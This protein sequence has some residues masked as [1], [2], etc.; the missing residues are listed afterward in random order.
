MTKA[1]VKKS[2]EKRLL[3][4]VYSNIKTFKP[5]KFKIGDYV[6]ISYNP[7]LFE[8]G[9][10]PN[11]STEIFQVRKVQLTNPVSY[12]LSDYQHNNVNGGFYEPELQLCN[13][14]KYVT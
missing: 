8:K 6:R 14:P 2:D 10:T 5:G 1:K 3:S 11:W 7:T 4:T 9:Y 12:L 13:Y